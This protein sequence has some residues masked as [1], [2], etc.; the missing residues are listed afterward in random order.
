MDDPL[1]PPCVVY[2]VVRTDPPA[3]RDFL[4]P[5]ALGRRFADPRQRELADGISVFATEVQARRQARRYQLGG[6]I[7]ELHLPRS[8]EIR[9][10]LR[11]TAGHHT[12]HADADALLAS[13]VRVV[14]VD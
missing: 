1:D 2:R 11:R 7:A 6:H 8:C 12:V 3:K 5:A 10:T 4:S 14:P 9:R 13:V